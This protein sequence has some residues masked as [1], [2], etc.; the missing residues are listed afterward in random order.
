ML[1]KLAVRHEGFLGLNLT[2]ATLDAVLKYPWLRETGGGEKERKYG[3]YHTEEEDFNWARQL[4]PPGNGDRCV[5]AEIMDWADDM[6]YALHDVDDFYRA[7][8][9]PLDTLTHRED[10]LDR[11][12]DFTITRWNQLG[13]DAPGSREELKT[14]FQKLITFVP[15]GEP[16]SGT[17]SQRSALRTLT[18]SLLGGYIAATRLRKPGAV[19]QS[20]PEISSTAHSTPCWREPDCRAFASMT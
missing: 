19:G 12:F 3:A 6:A 14:A 4:H 2:R 7:G 18:A 9:I 16:Y 11:F 17:R 10:E 15:V 8:F 20:R 1:T 13:K 5:E